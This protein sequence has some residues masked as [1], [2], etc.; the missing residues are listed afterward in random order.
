MKFNLRLTLISEVAAE[1]SPCTWH[2]EDG[3]CAYCPN[4]EGVYEQVDR[5]LYKD[6]YATEGSAVILKYGNELSSTPLSATVLIDGSEL[7]LFD[8]DGFLMIDR[9]ESEVRFQLEPRAE[10]TIEAA[11]EEEAKD[12]CKNLL[13]QLFEI[14]NSASEGSDG[15]EIKAVEIEKVT[16]L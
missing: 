6:Y 14:Y 2:D 7:P 11:S 5:F 10:I 13:P 12:L 16:A 3:R 8:S 9:D 4:D 15:L 1:D